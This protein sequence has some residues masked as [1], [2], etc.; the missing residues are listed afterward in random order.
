MGVCIVGVCVCGCSINLVDD[1]FLFFFVLDSIDQI[2]FEPTRSKWETF[3][4]GNEKGITK[5]NKTKK[6]LKQIRLNET[7]NHTD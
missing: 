2:L 7:L 3:R 1:F 6:I 5:Q 4:N